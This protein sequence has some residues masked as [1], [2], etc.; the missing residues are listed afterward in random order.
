[1]IL[2]TIILVAI[3]IVLIIALFTRKGIQTMVAIDINKPQQQVFDYLVLM[4]NQENY[5]AW[6]MIDPKMKK[7][8]TG[9]DGE[10]GF[11]LAWESKNKKDG[12]ASQRIVAIN[13]PEKIEIEL[14]F[15]SP[16]P[17][18]AHYRF[19]LTAINDTQTR[20][21]WIYEGNPTPYYFL[22]V[23]HLLLMLKKQATKYMQA[24]LNNLK[25]ILENQKL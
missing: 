17:S 12:K 1:M 24:S 13:A 3:P 14:I 18:T 7:D 4:K 5:N 22:R 16:V 2:I 10:Q 8:Y 6:L 23:S 21:N 20:V 11:L 9:T 15:E 19:E 25:N